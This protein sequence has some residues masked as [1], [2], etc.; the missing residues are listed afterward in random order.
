MVTINYRDPRPVYEQVRDGIRH[1][2][3][4][5]ALI[6]GERI[7]TV[8]DLAATLAINPNTIAHAYRELESEGYIISRVG[9][10]TFV[11]DTFEVD[12]SRKA[13]LMNKLGIIVQELL[14]LGVSV[15][16]IQKRI[17]EIESNEV[18]P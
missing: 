10:G 5:G 9:R 12:P 6:P 11:A 14:H 18:Q 1:H 15:E 17:I 13:A 2:I 4:T 7:P 8:R 3:I 16:M